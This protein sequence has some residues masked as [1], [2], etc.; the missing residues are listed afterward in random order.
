[1]SKLTDLQWEVKKILDEYAKDLDPTQRQAIQK[2]I[3][4]QIQLFGKKLIEDV[5]ASLS[6]I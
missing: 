3:N 1:M 4:R 6:E 2:Q 5:G